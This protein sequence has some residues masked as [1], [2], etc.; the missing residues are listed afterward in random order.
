MAGAHIEFPILNTAPLCDISFK[1]M[2]EL[3]D[4]GKTVYCRRGVL[5]ADSIDLRNFLPMLDL[6][7][8]TSLAYS[9]TD[10][11]EHSALF[12]I[13]GRVTKLMDF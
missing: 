10:K 13:E 5:R 12:L 2:A 6:N 3:S 7:M 8:A 4:S 9:I 11:T 1:R